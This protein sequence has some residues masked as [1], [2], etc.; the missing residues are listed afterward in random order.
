MDTLIK[1]TELNSDFILNSL[2]SPI[3]V[4]KATKKKI[5][6]CN[7]ATE[8]F[9]ET[10]EKNIVGKKINSLFKNDGY[11]LS[12]IE[13]SIK[14]NRNINELNVS[15][16]THKK[17]YNVSISISKIEND[18]NLFSI[19]LNDLSKS[20][21]L[22]KQFNFEKSAQSVS[23]LVGMLS[24]EIKNPLSGIKGA[25]QII[26]K[27]INFKGKDLNLIKLINNETERIKKLLNSLENFTDDRPIKKKSTNLNQVI[28]NSKESVEI[29]NNKRNI[30]FVENYDPS[31]PNI[32]GNEN[33]LTQLFVNL[34]NNAVEAINDVNGIIKISTRYQLGKLPIKVFIEDSGIGI[35]NELKENIFD[36]F[37]TNKI[38]GKGLGLSICAKIIQN[39][40]GTIEF[41]TINNKTIFTVMFEKI[42]K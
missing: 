18:N 33:Q 40:S 6:Y 31:L 1:N 41:D 17:K 21:E 19:I 4:I 11:F 25:S 23:S 35:P 8:V 28:R 26:Q 9:L 13:K 16:H 24:H 39:H 12:L 37:V 20:F 15:I 5:I 14:S 3:I 34:L 10:S 22:S 30:N 29:I 38:N 36:P 32:N 42:N 2:Q 27:R 7:N